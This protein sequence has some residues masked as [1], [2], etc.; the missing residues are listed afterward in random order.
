MGCIAFYPWLRIK[1][2]LTFSDFELIPFKLDATFQQLESTEED[3]DVKGVAK[4]YI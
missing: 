3:N 2:K 1:E 4:N